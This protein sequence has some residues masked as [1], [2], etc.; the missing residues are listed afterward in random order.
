MVA[1]Y[2]VELRIIPPGL[3]QPTRWS[4]KQDDENDVSDEEEPVQREPYDGMAYVVRV[5]GKQSMPSDS[6]KPHKQSLASPTSRSV[7][8]SRPITV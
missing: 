7:S 2:R 3:E 1:P 4:R 6:E 8:F 5:S